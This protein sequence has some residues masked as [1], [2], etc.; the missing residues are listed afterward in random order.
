MET[1]R[2]LAFVL[3]CL[4]IL[5]GVVHAPMHA[6]GGTDLF[7]LECSQAALCSGA[8]VL[9]FAMAMPLLSFAVVAHHRQRPTAV[10]VPRCGARFAHGSR[11]P[12]LR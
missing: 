4:M 12:P 9:L 1:L 7:G 8:V 11:G 10:S 3:L 2:R 5:V 6:A